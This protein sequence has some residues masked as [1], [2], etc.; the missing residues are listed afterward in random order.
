MQ[1]A[2][3]LYVVFGHIH[4]E[5]QF[6]SPFV[7]ILYPVNSA[8]ILTNGLFFFISGYGLWESRK[9]KKDYMSVWSFISRIVKLGVPAYI[10]YAAYYPIRIAVLQEEISFVRHMFLDGLFSWFR[11]NGAVWFLI[12]LFFLYLIFWT[13]YSMDRP[14]TGNVVLASCI[15]VWTIVAVYTGRGIVWYAS[16]FCFALGI[17]TSQCKKI[18]WERIEIYYRRA[19]QAGLCCFVIFFAVYSNVWPDLGAETACY[20]NLSALLFCVLCYLLM[21][22]CSVGNAATRQ[23][24]AVSYEFYLMNTMVIKVISDWNM[25]VVLKI[26]SIVLVTILLAV[27][28]HWAD[29][30]IIRAMYKFLKTCKVRM[31]SVKQNDQML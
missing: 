21:Y 24:G 12:V 4:D 3:A 14:G 10:I 5:V 26:Y 17:F 22:R 23:L 19:V 8:L 15:L 13:V 20:G 6:S 2:A 28:L 31:Q 18:I 29:S 7:W 1:G 16:T 25:G 9:S 27:L 11:Y 30:K